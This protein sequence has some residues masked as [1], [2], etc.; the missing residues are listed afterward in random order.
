MIKILIISDI[1]MP[2]MDGFEFAETVR[3]DNKT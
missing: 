1:M 2:N 3:F